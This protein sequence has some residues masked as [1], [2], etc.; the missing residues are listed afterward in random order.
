MLDE[1]QQIGARIR[2]LRDIMEVSAETLAAYLQIPLATLAD[3]ESGQA[4]LP[5]SVLYKLAIYF[6]VEFSVLLTGEEPK[7]HIYSI[8]RRGHGISI[9]RRKEYSHL[10]L[11][12]NFVD[13]K[14]EP[15]LVTVEPDTG[16][17]PFALNSHPGQEFNYVLKGSVKIAIGKHEVVL[18]E[19]DALYFDSSFPHGM[20][21]VGHESGAVF[22]GDILRCRI[23]DCVLPRG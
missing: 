12:A 14:A 21:A 13:K 5:V 2:G 19:G 10:S 22:S 9:D 16:Y 8:V 11:A 7:L 18:N 6:H 15:F 3:Y 20:K 4:D 1:L 23:Q 17:V